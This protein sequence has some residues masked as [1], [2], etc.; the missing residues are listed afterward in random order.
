MTYRRRNVE[1][2]RCAPSLAVRAS[3]CGPRLLGLLLIGLLFSSSGCQAFNK[4]KSDSLYGRL[5]RHGIEGTM[6]P[7]EGQDEL[8]KA[9]AVFD[10][11]KYAQAEPMFHKIAKKYKDKPIE[12]DAMFYI[13]EC[14]YNQERYAKAQDSYDELLNKYTSSRYIDQI[15]RRLFHIARTWIGTLQ[16]A[17]DIEQA[18]FLAESKDK[19]VPKEQLKPYILTLAPNLTDKTRPLFDP[20]GRALQA[21]KSIW[22][23]DPTGPLA[24]DALMEAATYHMRRRDF[25]EA[26]DLFNIIRSEYPQSE[27]AQTAYLLGSH[28]KLLTYQGSAYDGKQLEEA[29]KLTES[30]LRLFS[31]LEEKERLQSKLY[32]MTEARAARDWENVQFYLRKGQKT[33][34]AFYCEVVLREHPN[35]SYAAKAMA[36]LKKL[37]PP[38]K[39][40]GKDLGPADASGKEPYTEDA[41]PEEESNEPEVRGTHP[42][43]TKPAAPPRKIR[44]EDVEESDVDASASGNPAS[45]SPVSDDTAEE[46]IQ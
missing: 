11:K 18:E 40:P 27:H 9:K 23:K 3:A 34:A 32:Q 30:T 31:D 7:L 1:R 44:V 24:D 19:P 28:V 20:E 10:E 5:S 13:G 38:A 26:D 43:P 37:K 16:P 25:K 12:E 46:V 17:K 41:K 42:E 39:A 15:P 36:L 35:S 2:M 14:Q 33:S 45:D 8:D 21:L 4:N 6:G 22:L 29:Q